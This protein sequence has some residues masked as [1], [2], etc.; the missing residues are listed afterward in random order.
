MAYTKDVSNA[1]RC[2]DT[3]QTSLTDPLYPHGGAPF[4][5]QISGCSG[6][7][8]LINNS[9]QLNRQISGDGLVCEIIQPKKMLKSSHLRTDC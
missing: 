9:F 5:L 6:G 2:R 1:L 4:S 7:M 3:E 8:Y